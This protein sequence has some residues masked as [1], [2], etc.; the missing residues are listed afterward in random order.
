MNSLTA[1]WWALGTCLLAAAVAVA[2]V[3]L[4]YF[5]ENG[6]GTNPRGLYDFEV[7]TGKSALRAPVGGSQRFFSLDQRPSDGV[8]FAAEVVTG[9]ALW[10]INIDTG[11]AQFVVNH[12]LPTLADISFDPKTNSLYGMTRNVPYQLYT[13]DPGTGGSTLIGNLANEVRCG[14]TFSPSGTLYGFTLTGALYRIDPKT[15]GV[16]FVGDSGAP[17][18]LLEDADFT[19]DGRLFAVDWFGY[20]FQIDPS[21]GARTQVG[22]TGM[23]TGLTAVLGIPEPASMA[24][25]LTAGAGLRRRR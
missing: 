19:P 7:A 22:T 15:A 14:L 20:L 13:I 21:T 6:G 2:Q 23:G 4:V 16:T 5:D 3:D 9:N 12:G 8:V 17:M 10:T 18:S 24:L 25:L 11:A 1:R